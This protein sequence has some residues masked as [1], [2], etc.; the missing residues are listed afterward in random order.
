MWYDGL[1]ESGGDDDDGL[2]NAQSVL[3]E[4]RTNKVKDPYDDSGVKSRPS[5]PRKPTTKRTCGRAKQERRRAVEAARE[6]P[7]GVASCCV[8]LSVLRKRWEEAKQ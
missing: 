8:C 7:N 6:N 3:N 1:G 5:Q 2:D 4:S